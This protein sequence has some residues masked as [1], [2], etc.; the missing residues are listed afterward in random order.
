[1]AVRLVCGINDQ[2]TVVT[3]C[4]VTSADSHLECL[5]IKPYNSALMLL[6][7]SFLHRFGDVHMAD[8]S[9]MAPTRGRRTAATRELGPDHGHGSVN[10]EVAT[11]LS[12]Y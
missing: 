10:V 11:T 6:V 8:P 4:S 3:L 1:M 5:R 2:P 9:N 12:W 7:S